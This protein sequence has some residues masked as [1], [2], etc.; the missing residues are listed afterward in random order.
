MTATQSD[1]TANAG[2]PTRSLSLY[3]GLNST[4]SRFHELWTMR[5]V[6]DLQC[7]LSVSAKE[8]YLK[9][10]TCRVTALFLSCTPATKIRTAAVGKVR[11]TVLATYFSKFPKSQISRGMKNS[12]PTKYRAQGD[13]AGDVTY[14]KLKH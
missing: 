13:E 5:L 12:E 8:A 6:T 2:I 3:E 11:W 9:D 7:N 1:K 10:I 14:C 4:F